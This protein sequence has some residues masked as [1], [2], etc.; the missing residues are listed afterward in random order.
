M[1]LEEIERRGDM[2]VNMD[3]ILDYV[4][5]LLGPSGSHEFFD[6]DIIALINTVFMELNQIGIGP[7]KVFSIKDNTTT[8][9]EFLSP[10][11]HNF[12]AVKTYVYLRTKIIFDPPES[13]ALL[14]SI[15][16]QIDRLEWRLN[17]GAETPCFNGE[18]VN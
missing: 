17:V 10:D 15:N 11:D 5:K 1:S 14:E 4:K 2:E 16:R 7:S 9:D 13:S 3:S 6:P 12:E 18:G 8:W